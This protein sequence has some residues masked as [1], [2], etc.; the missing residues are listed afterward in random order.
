MKPETRI[1]LYNEQN[2]T[3]GSAMGNSHESREY[4][5]QQAKTLLT[6]VPIA[7]ICVPFMVLWQITKG[8]FNEGNRRR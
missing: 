2:R 3:I 7:L 8:V 1:I 6:W 4:F 5:L